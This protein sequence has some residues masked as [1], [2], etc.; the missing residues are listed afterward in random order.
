MERRVSKDVLA[1]EVSR[2]L[3]DTQEKR[4]KLENL[5]LMASMEKRAK[6]VW[7]GP[8]EK[9]ETLAEEVPKVP[10]DKQET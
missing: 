10:K 7:L 9:E 3:V 8:L 2:G 1:R 6:V 4:V 5:V